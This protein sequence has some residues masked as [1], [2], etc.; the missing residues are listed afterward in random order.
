MLELLANQPLMAA[1][2]ALVAVARLVVLVPDQP[3]WA[4]VD[5]YQF[6]LAGRAGGGGAPAAGRGSMRR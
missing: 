5:Y 6:W 4:G 1:L 2:L 3:D